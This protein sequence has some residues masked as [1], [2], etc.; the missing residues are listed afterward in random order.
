MSNIGDKLKEQLFQKLIPSIEIRQGGIYRV[1][2][3][4]NNPII[5]FP[6]NNLPPEHPRSKRTFHKQRYVL[7]MQ[8][9]ELNQN[10]QFPHVQVIPLTSQGRETALTV[11]IADE[12]LAQEL[13][14]PSCAL[15]YLSQSILKIFLEKEVGFIPSSHPI[16]TKI[17]SI[18]LRLIGLL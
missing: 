10:N 14:G 17:R 15:V 11:E 2:D 1:V 16:F 18:Y 3:D 5:K 12:F 4:P 9:D 7:V 8:N 13:P 6:E